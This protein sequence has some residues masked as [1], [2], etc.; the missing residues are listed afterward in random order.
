[1]L[2]QITEP[3]QSR[4]KTYLNV[5]DGAIVKRTETGEEVSFS[6][7][8]GKLSDVFTKERTFRTERVLYWYIDLRDDTGELFSIGLPYN[9]GIFKSI[10]LAL[11]SDRGLQAIRGG[12]AIKIEPYT[13]NGFDKVQVSTSG[14]RLD[15]VTK[16]LPAMEEITIGG[17]TIKDDTKRMEFISSLADKVKLE[18]GKQVGN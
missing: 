16:T 12:E 5:K 4:R 10:I 17:R 7:V 3:K 6:F 2:G 11:A 9:S 14:T 8:E 1:M 13:K 15:W 18:I